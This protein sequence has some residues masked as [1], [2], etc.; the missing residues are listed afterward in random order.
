MCLF[1]LCNVV[2][3]F[4]N[5]SLVGCVREQV[6]AFV[7]DSLTERDSDRVLTNN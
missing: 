5:L 7:G 4:N 6:R 2:G 1:I 3:L